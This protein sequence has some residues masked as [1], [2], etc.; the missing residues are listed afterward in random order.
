MRP[1]ILANNFLAAILGKCLPHSAAYVL[2]F[3]GRINGPLSTLDQQLWKVKPLWRNLHYFNV[4]NAKR[5]TYSKP[6]ADKPTAPQR[7]CRQLRPM[8]RKCGVGGQ[9]GQCGDQY[10]RP[11]IQFISHLYS[12]V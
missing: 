10:P 9:A 11:S 6:A 8:A 2:D 3:R 7:Q 12:A 1:K 4:R 5:F